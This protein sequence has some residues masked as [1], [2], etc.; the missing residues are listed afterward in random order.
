MKLAAIGALTITQAAALLIAYP[1]SIAWTAPPFQPA[2]RWATDSNVDY[3]QDA[4]RVRQ[5]SL[6]KAPFEA[7]LL[8]RGVDAP[9]GS[10]PL[11]QTSP[12]QVHGWAA[13]SATRLTALDRD[14]LSWL[15][16]YCPVRTIG[17]SVLIYRFES[18]VDPRPG[19][20]MPAAPCTG[21]VSTRRP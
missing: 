3:G 11:L 14:A 17:G 8:P 2:Y 19:P 21:G 12:D 20:T 15:R 5:W 7:L 18:P 1:H 9:E 16:A 4:D 13:V 6:G 10:R